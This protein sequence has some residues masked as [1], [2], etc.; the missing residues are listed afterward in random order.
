M[1]L[2]KCRIRGLDALIVRT[3]A[4]TQEARVLEIM[5]EVWLKQEFGMA[6]GDVETV[7]LFT[8]EG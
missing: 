8:E 1:T 6:D 3:S 2:E 4:S 7:E 5:S